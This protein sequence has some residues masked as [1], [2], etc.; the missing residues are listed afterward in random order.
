MMRWIFALL[1][2]TCC[3]PTY[4]AAP[5]EKKPAATPKPR[6]PPPP[7]DLSNTGIP[8]RLGEEIEV[9]GYSTVW[10]VDTPLLIT[11]KT[12]AWDHIGG[13]E[14]DPD[15]REGRARF[16]FVREGLS[17]VKTIEE[18]QTATVYGFQIT[19]NHAYELYQDHDAR[20]VPHAKFIVRR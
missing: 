3:A 6:P 11:L 19:V 9:K 7:P 17:K 10:L 15:S 20:W 14:N 12:T 5:V 16:I 13:D 8:V 18:G 1:L 4:G 2:L